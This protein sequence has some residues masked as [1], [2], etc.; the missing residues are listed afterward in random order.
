MIIIPEPDSEPTGGLYL[1]L[2]GRDEGVDAIRKGGGG[3]GL[4]VG[5]WLRAT[6]ARELAGFWMGRMLS[7]GS[8]GF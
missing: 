6:D 7:A 8:P 4:S 1:H 2:G 5:V 3:E